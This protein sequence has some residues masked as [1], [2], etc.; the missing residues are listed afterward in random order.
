MTS[1][2]IARSFD[3]RPGFNLVDFEEVGLPV[4]RLTTTVLTLQ[5]KSYSPIEEFILR[6]VEAGLDTIELVAGFLGISESIVEAT[7][8]LLV[9][10]DELVVSPDGILRLTRKS[11]RVLAGES[12][13]QPREQSLVFRY[14]GLTRRPIRTDE[15]RLWEPRDL[16]DRGIREIRAFPAKRPSPE[17]ISGDDLQTV[18]RA[19]SQ[20][21][22]PSVQILHVKSVTRAFANFI[23]ALALVYRRASGADVQVAFA[24]DGRLSRDHEA[25]F[26]ASDGP[27]RMGIT[28][29]I[30]QQAPI[31]FDSALKISVGAL[32]SADAGSIAQREKA[33]AKLRSQIAKKSATGGAADEQSND[34]EAVANSAVQMIP[35]YEHAPLLRL[36]LEE[37][38]ERLIII[39]PWITDAVVD[40]VFLSRLSQQLQRGVMVYIG[41]GLGNEEKVPTAVK[42]LEKLAREHSGFRLVRLGDT[43]AKVLIKDNDWLV[44]TS[45]NWLSFRGDPKRTF[46]EEWGTKVSLPDQVSSYAQ[47]ILKRLDQTGGGRQ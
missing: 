14:D 31:V 29:A 35:V 26:A 41:Y 5:P 10:D 17:E 46:R 38:R 9:K 45:F 12:L 44:T 37:A 20:V 32:K 34:A 13:I 19:P 7:A 16:K 21:G 33:I 24:I 27:A 6:A 18:L 30:L 43:H 15:L 22:E 23:P 2:E 1:D 39:S 42:H 40:Q 3:D 4:Y 47:T 28:A 36:A 11:E 8:S 25:A